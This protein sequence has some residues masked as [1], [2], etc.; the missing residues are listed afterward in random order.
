MGKIVPQVARFLLPARLQAKASCLIWV[1]AVVL[2]I[3]VRLWLVSIHSLNGVGISPHDSGLFF[4]LAVSLL[5]GNWLGDYDSLI[6]SKGP[7]YS[8]WM[9]LIHIMELPLLMVQQLLYSVACLVFVL[10]LQP[11]LRNRFWLWA[12]FVLLLFNPMSYSG[13]IGP[14]AR[15]IRGGIYTSLT[16]LVLAGAIGLQTHVKERMNYSMVWAVLLGLCFPLYWMTREEGVWILP[17]VLLLMAGAAIQ[18]WRSGL[19]R[20]YSY[21]IIFIPLMMT[22]VIITIVASINYTH[23]GYWGVVDMKSGGFQ[24]AYGALGRVKHN[25]WKADI[26]VPVDVRKKVYQISPGFSELEEIMEGDWYSDFRRTSRDKTDFGGGWFMWALRGAVQDKGYYQSFLSADSFYRRMADE[27]NQ[28][29]ISESISCYPERSTMMPPLHS[30][31]I[32]PF[33]FALLDVYNYLITFEGFA[34]I[35]TD[36]TGP[37]ETLIPL[38]YMT[39]NHLEPRKEIRGKTDWYFVTG[40]M[41]HEILPLNYLIVDENSDPVPMMGEGLPSQ[42]LYDFYEREGQD[43]INAKGAKFEFV[44]QCKG[45]CIMIINIGSKGE[46]FELLLEPPFKVIDRDGLKGRLEHSGVLNQIFNDRNPAK[47]NRKTEMLWKIYKIYKEVLP[48]ASPFSVLMLISMTILVLLTKKQRSFII[49]GYALAGAVLARVSIIALIDISSFP[50]MNTLYLAP[51]YPIAIALVFL[52][53][54]EAG[55]GVAQNLIKKFVTIQHT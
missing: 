52:C 38:R 36:S 19:R 46:S 50:A 53:L 1:A 17:S 24:S 48:W 42:E 3:V 8:L 13:E 25:N 32:K 12:L 10:A 9:A 44:Y 21:G 45:R 35:N 55:T 34:A 40:W 54:Y 29:C 16:L 41:F 28:A 31:Y 11:L 22:F 15:I 51:A 23:Y 37:L 27:I 26:P 20:I 49:I 43:F 5:E 18:L 33:F 7:V 47:W 39:H 6:L 4:R 30:T 2:I 14:A